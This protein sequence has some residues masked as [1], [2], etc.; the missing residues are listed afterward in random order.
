MEDLDF[1]VAHFRT[2]VQ[3]SGDQHLILAISQLSDQQ[4]VRMR[5]IVLGSEEGYHKFLNEDGEEYG[6]FL[7]YEEDEEWYWVSQFPG[8][9]P[10]GE[11]S[12]PFVTSTEAYNDAIDC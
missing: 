2:R 3:N 5:E 11:P 1:D 12:G 8:C 9:L 6:S 10:D 4:I 7:V